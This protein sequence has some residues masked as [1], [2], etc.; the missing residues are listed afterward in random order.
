MDLIS[1]TF[2]PQKDS[3]TVF[4]TSV[5]LSFYPINIPSKKT[6]NL[7]LQDENAIKIIRNST[8]VTLTPGVDPLPHHCHV[9]HHS[10]YE[11][12]KRIIGNAAAMP[13]KA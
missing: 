4:A 3:A 11:H 12:K 9:E 2:G 7:L 8:M 10:R 6:K 5:S 13:N 1:N